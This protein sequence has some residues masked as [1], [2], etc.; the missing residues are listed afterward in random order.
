[1]PRE[2]QGAV[3][4]SSRGMTAAPSRH[5]L[6]FRFSLKTYKNFTRKG[7]VHGYRLTH[8]APDSTLML[9]NIASILPAFCLATLIAVVVAVGLRNV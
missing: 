4:G 7:T 9:T 1:M 8:R 5:L 6:S 3:D 2:T